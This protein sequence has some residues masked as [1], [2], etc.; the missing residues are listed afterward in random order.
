VLSGPQRKGRLL[1]EDE[2]RRIATH[3]AGH[4][5]LAAA[6]GHAEDVQR[7]SV[8]ARGR[9]LGSV[10]LGSDRDAVLLT[11]SQ[12]QGQLATALSGRAAEELVFGEP[13]TGSD[14]TSSTRRTSPATSSPDTG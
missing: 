9:G 12:L 8:V 5:I 7:I 14:A 3:E 4:A 1:T 10:Q 11:R 13:S 6:T 2:R